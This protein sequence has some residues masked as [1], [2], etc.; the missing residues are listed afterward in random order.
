M[1]CPLLQGCCTDKSGSGSGTTQGDLMESELSLSAEIFGSSTWFAVLGRLDVCVSHLGL[2][3]DAQDADRT[4]RNRNPGQTNEG[5][6]TENEDMDVECGR[7]TDCGKPDRETEMNSTQSSE[8]ETGVVLVSEKESA[9][10]IVAD[11]VVTVVLPWLRES[12]AAYFDAMVPAHALSLRKIIRFVMKMKFAPVAKELAPLLRDIVLAYREALLSICTSG[13]PSPE[14]FSS[15]DYNPRVSGADHEN[16]FK[17]SA[18]KDVYLFQYWT[19]R[20]RLVQ[21]VRAELNGWKGII[22]EPVLDQ[23]SKIG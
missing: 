8:S 21:K 17:V 10:S 22:A 1:H 9:S 5:N 3:S 11:I 6:D 19:E 2:S 12:V 7:D 13:P 18:T 4:P 16:R 15:V 14:C 20:L 23:L